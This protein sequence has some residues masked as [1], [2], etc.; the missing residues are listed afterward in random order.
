MRILISACLLGLD[1]RYNGEGKLHE[2]CLKLKEKHAL[3][4]VC[5]EQLGGLPTPRAASEIIDGDGASVLKGLS[6]VMDGE[7]VDETAGFIKGAHETLKLYKA[8][9]CELAVLKARSPSCGC[10]KIY[11]G[12]FSKGLKDGNGVTV[13]LLQANGIKVLTEEDIENLLY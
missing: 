1:C 12:T 11:D 5:P 13:E 3:V 9:D 8:L 4:P 6:R 10:G 7:G 2:E